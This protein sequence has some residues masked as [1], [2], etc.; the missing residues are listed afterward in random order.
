MYVPMHMY[1]YVY[2]YVCMFCMQNN[3][4]YSTYVYIRMHIQCIMYIP[5]RLIAFLYRIPLPS[6]TSSYRPE[7]VSVTSTNDS[8][9]GNWNTLNFATLRGLPSL[10]NRNL[11][12]LVGPSYPNLIMQGPPGGAVIVSL[13]EMA[14]AQLSMASTSQPEICLQ[15]ILCTNSRHTVLIEIK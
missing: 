15:A 7:S 13:R 2:A 12:P 5:K 6:T 8:L 4:M 10:V 14:A 11:I 3:S 9:L 1:R